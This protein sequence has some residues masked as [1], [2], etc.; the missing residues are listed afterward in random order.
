[1]TPTAAARDMPDPVQNTIDALLDHMHKVDEE[2]EELKKKL[3][4]GHPQMTRIS[5]VEKTLRVCVALR[6][7]T[8]L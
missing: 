8:I 1:M 5:T 4:Q 6:P 3:E 7:G 2:M